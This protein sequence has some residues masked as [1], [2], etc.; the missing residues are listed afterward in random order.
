VHHAWPKTDRGSGPAPE[1]PRR[2]QTDIF[3]GQ[4]SSVSIA[5]GP[6]LQR[7]RHRRGGRRRPTRRF[8]KPIRALLCGGFEQSRGSFGS[9][10]RL[11]RRSGH[12]LFDVAALDLRHPSGCRRGKARVF[13]RFVLDRVE[14]QPV[15]RAGHGHIKTGP[16][17][18]P[19]CEKLPWGCSSFI[20]SG[21]EFE[22]SRAFLPAGK[23]AL[24]QNARHRRDRIRVPSRHETVIN[25]T[26]IL[27]VPVPG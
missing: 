2:G 22:H 26:A 4:D 3:W 13:E 12:E 14:R 27:P 25:C 1:D 8:A 21:G 11:D 16:A 6:E 9:H 18:L 17:P 10:G 15:A 20:N 23:T 5:E 19:G 24:Y 7:F